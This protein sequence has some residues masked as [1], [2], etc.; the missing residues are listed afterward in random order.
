MAGIEEG[1]D[2]AASM[3]LHDTPGDH[4]EYERE[5]CRAIM[6]GGVYTRDRAFRHGL[7]GVAARGARTAGGR[8]ARRA[9]TDGGNVSTS[10]IS[11]ARCSRLNAYGNPHP[12]R[13]CVDLVHAALGEL[14]NQEGDAVRGW[15]VRTPLLLQAAN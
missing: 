1:I 7:K 4:T 2:R 15:L 10:T 9:F 12:L 11:G 6:M 3:K 13:L 8:C 14:A 5:C